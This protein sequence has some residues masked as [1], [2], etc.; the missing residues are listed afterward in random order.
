MSLTRA[1]AKLLQSI[2]VNRYLGSGPRHINAYSRDRR[3]LDEIKKA[4]PEAINFYYGGETINVGENI[5]KVAFE[6]TP[7][8]VRLLDE[9]DK[10]AVVGFYGVIEVKDNRG[11]TVRRDFHYRSD[12]ESQL[13]QQIK[14]GV[15]HYYKF[16]IVELHKM[17]HEQ[18][19]AAFGWG[20][21]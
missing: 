12:T 6:T 5:G 3:L 18:W 14:R 10:T 21:M 11:L 19:V 1:Q 17:T 20:R 13:R 9:Y 2:I 15:A 4:H 16:D 8:A 7:D